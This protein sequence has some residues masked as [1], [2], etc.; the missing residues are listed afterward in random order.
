MPLPRAAGETASGP[1]SP[2]QAP[3]ASRD[4]ASQQMQPTTAP[5]NTATR[6]RL[7]DVKAS[8]SLS[9][10]NRSPVLKETPAGGAEIGA[11]TTLHCER[12]PS[13][14]PGSFST[15]YAAFTTLIILATSFSV[16][17]RTVKGD[18]PS[19]CPAAMMVS[20]RR[21]RSPL[22]NHARH[23]PCTGSVR[24]R[25]L[26]SP[27]PL[28]VVLLY[29]AAAIV[30]HL[31]VAWPTHELPGMA[32]AYASRMAIPPEFPQVL[33]D[34]AREVLR[35][36]PKDE[37]PADPGGC[38]AEHGGNCLHRPASHG[39]SL[40][41]GAE[42]WIL[43]FGARYFGDASSA[44]VWLSPLPAG[45]VDGPP[46][47]PP[48]FVPLRSWR[49]GR[50]PLPVARGDGRAHPGDFPGCRQGWQRRVGP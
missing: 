27:E 22:K 33:K 24:P 49:R 10:V 5:S 37:A 42:A 18:A 35:N 21:L 26:H 47:S 39:P 7:S 28:P 16:E 25:T 8:T 38:W 30:W 44:G 29:C 36:Y 11:Q 31:T 43:E 45:R 23:T 50:P 9:S 32:S 3:E 41:H 46:H 2:T 4:K 12:A 40:V 48:H 6:H 13:P 15:E 17:L 14:D 1:N 19:A 34:F 20:L